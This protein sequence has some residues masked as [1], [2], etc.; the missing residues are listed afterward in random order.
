M[1]PHRMVMKFKRN[2][3]K[4]LA[5]NIVSNKVSMEQYQQLH[6]FYTWIYPL[7]SFSLFIY[8]T[9]YSVSKPFPVSFAEA[10]NIP[11]FEK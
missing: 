10:N 8:F 7:S 3:E 5:Q 1:I 9:D 6:C 2:F 11:S 4:Y